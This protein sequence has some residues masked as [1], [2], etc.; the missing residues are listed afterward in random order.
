MAGGQCCGKGFARLAR[1]FVPIT[2]LKLMLDS[3]EAL[4]YTKTTTQPGRNQAQSF[5]VGQARFGARPQI[6]ARGSGTKEQESLA[7]YLCLCKGLTEAD[8]KR[9]A[10]CGS[11]CVETLIADLGLEDDDCCGR[12]AMDAQEF[13]SIAATEWD[14]IQVGAA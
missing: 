11:Q 8:V 10:R 6:V 13:E 7:V 2:R 5:G 1:E 12:C 4:V 3:E 9:Q 14:F